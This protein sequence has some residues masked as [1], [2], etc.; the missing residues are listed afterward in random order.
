MNTAGQEF[1]KTRVNAAWSQTMN[2]GIDMG[3]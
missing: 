3:V 2:A 1:P